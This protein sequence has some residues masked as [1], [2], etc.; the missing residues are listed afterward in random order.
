MSKKLPKEV[1]FERGYQQWDKVSSS[2]LPMQPFGVF[3][4]TLSLSLCMCVYICVCVCQTEDRQVESQEG[5]IPHFVQTPGPLCHGTLPGSMYYSWGLCTLYSANLHTAVPEHRSITTAQ[6]PLEF[7]P[8]NPHL[9]FY[10]KITHTYGKIQNKFVSVSPCAHMGTLWVLGL[11]F[12]IG[13]LIVAFVSA[14]G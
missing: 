3:P 6:N 7:S 4:L 5:E 1:H 12:L 14:T 13:K 8:I 2:L 10:M 11:I 9:A